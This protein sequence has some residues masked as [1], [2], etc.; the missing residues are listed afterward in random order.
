[1]LKQLCAVLFAVVV[2]AGCKKTKCGYNECEIVAPSS[3]VQAVEAYLASQNITSAVKHCSGLYYVIDTLGTGQYANACATVGVRYKGMLKDGSVF[4]QGQ[5]ALSLDG[6]INGW[7]NGIPLVKEGGKIRL[8]IPPTLGYGS[9][10]IPGIPG[11]SILIF[12]VGVDL[13][14]L[15]E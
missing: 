8:F 7:R 10:P 15:D 4:D 9:N 6:V 12:E 11:N 14:A 2:F 13:V 3:E 5:T 1:M